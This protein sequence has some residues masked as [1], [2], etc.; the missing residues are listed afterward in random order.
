M[1]DLLDNN[2]GFDMVSINDLR[3]KLFDNEPITPEEEKAIENFDKYRLSKLSEVKNDSEFERTYLLIR[4][5]ANV[6]DYHEFL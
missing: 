2:V 3:E 6:L 5:Q 1:N 4:A